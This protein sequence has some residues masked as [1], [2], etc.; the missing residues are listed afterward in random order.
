MAV[1]CTL[2]GNRGENWEFSPGIGYFPGDDIR[3]SSEL[4]AGLVKFYERRALPLLLGRNANT[5]HEFWGRG[6]T[7][8]RGEYLL[9][10]IL[11]NEL[12]MYNIGNPPTFESGT[13]EK[14][15]D[16]TLVMSRLVGNWKFSDGFPASLITWQSLSGRK[17]ILSA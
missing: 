10:F 15:L 11:S 1:H 6:E 2:T 17:S 13:R 3:I 14:I 8:R 7:S 16:I 4:V 5:H 12:E 9:E